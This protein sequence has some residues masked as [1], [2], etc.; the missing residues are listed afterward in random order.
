MVIMLKRLDKTSVG[1]QGK[2]STILSILLYENV[3]LSTLFAKKN[4]WICLKIKICEFSKIC[5]IVTGIS[6]ISCFRHYCEF[7]TEADYFPFPVIHTYLEFVF[8]SKFVKL[9]QA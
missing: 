9:W 8:V 5:Q 3:D 1:S 6:S 7:L 2:Y 4:G